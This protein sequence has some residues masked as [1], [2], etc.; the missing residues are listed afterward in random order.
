MRTNVNFRGFTMLETLLAAALLGAL[1]LALNFFIFSMAE[2]WG[3]GAE[4]RLFEQHTRAVTREVETW[5]RTATL[6]PLAGA[7]GVFAAEIQLEDSRREAPLSFL[8]AGGSPRLPW[9]EAALPEVVGSLVVESGRGLVLYWQSRLET[10]FDEAR[11]RSWVVSQ[12][13]TGLSYE[14]QEESGWRR[15]ED[16][17][18]GNDGQWRIPG[19]LHLQFEHAGM[20]SETSITL[21]GT[22]APLPHF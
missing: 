16:L 10:S 4:R 17:E 21:P 3:A 20:K 8:L 18:R 6:P 1:L 7:Q 13:V 2:I 9:P 15:R 22:L 5:L 11:P 12:F 14:Y 19:R